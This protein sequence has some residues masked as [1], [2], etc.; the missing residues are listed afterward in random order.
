MTLTKIE[1][2]LRKEQPLTMALLEATQYDLFIYSHIDRSNNHECWS[3]STYIE[4]EDIDVLAF[5]T[6]TKSRLL[7]ENKW[8]TAKVE[9]FLDVIDQ[10]HLYTVLTLHWLEVLTKYVPELLS[11]H[12][13]VSIL[14]R[15]H[16]CQVPASHSTHSTHLLTTSRA[17]MKLMTESNDALVDFSGQIGQSVEEFQKQLLLISADG[18]TCEKIIQLKKYLQ[19]METSFSGS[20]FSSQCFLYSCWP[21]VYVPT[22]P[23][24]AD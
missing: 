13:H 6:S 15:I 20:K 21:I 14:F 8:T 17:R 10:S 23:S 18:L 9:D 12:E 3:S 7:D 22:R 19:A 2:T 1:Q 11:Y 5:D 4:L 16:R 24:K